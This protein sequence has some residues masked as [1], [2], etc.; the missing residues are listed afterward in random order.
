LSVC[1]VG[2]SG[3]LL[4]ALV[5]AYHGGTA[6]EGLDED[7]GLVES[8]SKAIWCLVVQCFAPLLKNS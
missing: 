2:E 3:D 8:H 6:V 5:P 1:A 4:V 7:D